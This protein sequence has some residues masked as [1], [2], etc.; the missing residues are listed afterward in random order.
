MD[1][2][3]I[4]QFAFALLLASSLVA[5]QSPRPATIDDLM[6]L[7][8]VMDAQISPDGSTV[9]YVESV[10]NLE[11]DKHNSDVWLI[12]SDGGDPIQLTNSPDMDQNPRWSPDGKTLA[13][14]TVRDGPPQIYLINPRGGE[15]S[16]LT[17]SETGVQSFAWSPDGSRILYLSQ[18]ALSEET[19]TA[20]EERGGVVV[21][22]TEFQMNHLHSVA[23]EGG[24]VTDVTDG[25]YTVSSYQW[26]PDGTQ[27]AFS[28]QPTA[29]VPDGNR[30]DIFVISAEGGKA[31]ALVERPGADG[32]PSWSPNGKHIAFVSAHG[33]V[34]EVGSPTLG[35]VRVSNG[36][37]RRL[38]PVYEESPGELH[39]SADSK[40][41]YFSGTQGVSY[42]LFRVSLDDNS[43]TALSPEEE[44][45]GS[46]SLST[47]GDR[48]AIITTNPTMPPEVFISP[49]PQI[50]MKR[51]TT[52]N[53]QLDELALGTMES[54]RWKSIDGMEIEGI[55][56]KPANYEAGKRY[57]LL[58]YVH[59]GPSGLF[60]LGF[61]PQLGTFSV[62]MQAAPYPIQAFAGRGFAMFMPNPRG[63][64]GYGREFQRANIRD[65][66]YGDFQDIQSGIDHLVAQG[67]ADGDALGLMGW[68]YGGYMTS[69]AI[70][71]TDRFKAAS[72][73]AGL[74]NMYSMHGTT[75]IPDTLLAYYGDRPWN[76]HEV[77]D[78]SSAMRF[79]GN[80]VTPTLIQHGEKDE[81]VQLSQAWEMYRALQSNEVPASFAIY[82]EQGHLIMVPKQQRDMQKRNYEWFSKWVLPEH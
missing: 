32:S 51:L 21:V 13:F 24:E 76:D 53:P 38:G 25:D 29:R 62:A 67:I 49:F 1:L 5:A 18:D 22:D 61:Y 72:I 80:I 48:A 44:I 77:Y 31:S 66:G 57:P 55:L 37:I 43:V 16:Q 33:E 2:F 52:T 79:A 78:R 54:V 39:W 75:D 45:F 65:W 15:A 4:N 46:F 68:S 12:S 50:S 36:K 70:T 7:K 27:V 9:A 14:M 73:G 82:P 3:R 11:K 63:S 28:S 81:R 17:K 30:S 40:S 64:S 71:Q 58:T 19:K 42:R 26:S 10:P 74:P 56:L 41:I 59:G 69:W 23:I 8:T 47:E 34:N 6:G 35:L 20:Q 60:T